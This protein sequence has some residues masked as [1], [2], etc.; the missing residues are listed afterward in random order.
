MQ[1]NLT[2]GNK[3][4]GTSWDEGDPTG[5]DLGGLSPAYLL[6]KFI[7]FIMC[8]G[9]KKPNPCLVMDTFLFFTVDLAL[10]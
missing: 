7:A 8:S 6:D 3:F 5:T 4:P 9:E 2:A 1:L 10:R